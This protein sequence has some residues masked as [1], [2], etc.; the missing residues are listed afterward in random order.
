MLK[1]TV[2]YAQPT[3]PQSFEKYYG[4][5]HTPLIGKVQGIEKVEFTRF[6]PNADDTPAACYRMA[7]LYFA[8]PAEMQQ[9]LS[10]P[11]G[12]ALAADLPNFATGG[13]TVMVGVVENFI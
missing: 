11:E 2:L 10:S 1:V 5:T 8:G 13:A 4:D 6:M 7:E 12:Q 3:D 9:A